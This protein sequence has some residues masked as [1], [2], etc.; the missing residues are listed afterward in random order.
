[1]TKPAASFSDVK[2]LLLSGKNSDSAK[3]S[4]A[5][6]GLTSSQV[7]IRVLGRREPLILPLIGVWARVQEFLLL[8]LLLLLKTINF[9]SQHTPVTPVTPVTPSFP[10]FPPSPPSPSRGWGGQGSR[11]NLAD[12]SRTAKSCFSIL[13]T[14]YKQ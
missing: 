14:N 10:P 9:S 6:R 3:K 13:V 4:P 8:L 2:I 11:L 1:M 7:R 5:A 12:L